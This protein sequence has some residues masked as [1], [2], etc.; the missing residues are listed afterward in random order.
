MIQ[1]DFLHD[2][3]P[4]YVRRV[5]EM[6]IPGAVQ[7]AI[8]GLAGALVVLTGTWG[9]ESY[10][11]RQADEVESRYQTRFDRSVIELARTKVAYDRL[12]RMVALDSQIATIERS[13]NDD[14]SRLAE[15]ANRL[16]PHA[17]L[18]SISRD[19]GGIAIEGRARD[20]TVVGRTIG[21]LAKSALLQNPTLLEASSVSQADGDGEIRYRVH[22]DGVRP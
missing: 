15:I 6:R 1:F 14:A 12:Q 18:T 5:L 11:L 2:P 9:I 8:L 21:G 7:N 20:F 16:P 10:R 22:L 19:A 13:G 3:R 4:A 17:W